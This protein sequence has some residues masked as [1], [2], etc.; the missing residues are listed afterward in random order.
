MANGLFDP[1]INSRAWFDDT[2]AIQGW[3]DPS[4]VNQ[5]TQELVDNFDD[6][7]TNTSLWSTANSPSETGGQLS[8]PTTAGTTNYSQYESKAY[9]DI[10]ASYVYSQVVNAGN[11]ALASLQAIPV[12]V[13]LDSNNS[14]AWYV[15]AGFIHA[16]KQ[17]AGVF[18]DVLNTTAYNSSVHK[19]FKIRESAGTIY[20]D[21]STDGVTYTNYTSLANPFSVTNLKV[22]ISAGTYSAEA[23][24]S[25]VI[26]DNLNVA[27]A[28]N[29]SLTPGTLS[30]VVSTFAPT[31][32]A[33]NNIFLTPGVATITVTT[34]APTVT[35]SNNVSVIPGPASLA[36]TTF[37]PT[38]TAT[39]NIA[40][41]PGFATLTITTFA[42]TVTISDNIIVTP[43]A[44]TLTINTF[45]PV[46]TVGA[47][48]N[49]SPNPATI[50]IN[51]FAPTVSVSDSKIVTPDPITVTITTF[52]PIVTVS[53]NKQVTPGPASLTI[54]TFRPTVTVSGSTV[55]RTWYLDAS[56]NFYWVI[57]Q[58]A[59]LIER[60]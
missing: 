14:L 48:V 28:S 34:F 53:D 47:G 41:T 39:N 18:T 36:I 19:Y 23:S 42:P 2:L 46:V 9:Y 12:Q 60:L 16:Q 58:T 1:K 22:R 4:L 54:T 59:G 56:G 51:T 55:S 27:P 29:T 37:A 38:V 11:Q 35:A 33:S 15:N 25:T 8:L 45:A 50:T 52:A 32:V 31:V 5:R 17:V 43:D 3:F 26:I 30:L 40:V 10:T 49:V 21:Y 13:V 57:S 6:N 7:S 20:W 44:A 24:S